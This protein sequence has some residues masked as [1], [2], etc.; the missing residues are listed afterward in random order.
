MQSNNKKTAS[1]VALMFLSAI[2]TLA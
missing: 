1:R 2:A